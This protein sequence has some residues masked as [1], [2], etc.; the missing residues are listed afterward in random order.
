MDPGMT[1]DHVTF[2]DIALIYLSVFTLL[3]GFLNL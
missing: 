3:P 2:P 1:T